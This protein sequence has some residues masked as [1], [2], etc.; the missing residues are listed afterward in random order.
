MSLRFAFMDSFET[1]PRQLIVSV[2][3][4]TLLFLG[5][6]ILKPCAFRSYHKLYFWIESQAAYLSPLAKQIKRY[7]KGAVTQQLNKAIRLWF[8]IEASVPLGVPHV[9]RL[10]RNRIAL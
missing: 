8:V 7:P 2:V 9:S 5:S 3:L 1:N 6:Q 10:S 4:L